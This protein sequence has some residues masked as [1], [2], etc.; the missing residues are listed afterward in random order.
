MAKC[1]MQANDMATTVNNW[2]TPGA[3]N[4]GVTVN[5]SVPFLFLR[6]FVPIL[7]ICPRLGGTLDLLGLDLYLSKIGCC[8]GGCVVIV[9]LYDSCL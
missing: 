3:S 6:K 9:V 1:N 5:S 2:K 8:D 4:R 7:E